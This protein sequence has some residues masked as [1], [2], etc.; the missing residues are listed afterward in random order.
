MV[1][2]LPSTM[3]KGSAA[4]FPRAS[5]IQR[6][7]SSWEVFSEHDAWL[8]LLPVEELPPSGSSVK[9][10]RV[11]LSDD[12]WLELV[13]TFDGLGL[14]SEV[15][16]SDPALAVDLAKEEEEATLFILEAGRLDMKADWKRLAPSR[17]QDQ[18]MRSSCGLFAD[19]FHLPR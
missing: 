9:S 10:Q 3:C 5:T 12:R 7:R 19:S 4:L 17:G 15:S 18:L 8:A 6:K 13:L 11:E 14:N 16:Y 2:S 1:R